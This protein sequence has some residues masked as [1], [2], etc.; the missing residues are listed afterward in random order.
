MHVFECRNRRVNLCLL[1]CVI[2]EVNSAQAGHNLTNH[3]LD[4]SNHQV[5]YQERV[6]V[7]QKNIQQGL[8][9]IQLLY[10]SIDKK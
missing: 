4:E 3:R 2:R 1:M 7:M 9:K 8:L 5:R 10:L 6:Q